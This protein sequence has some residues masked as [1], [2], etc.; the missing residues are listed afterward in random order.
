MSWCPNGGKRTGGISLWDDAWATSELTVLLAEFVRHTSA[1]ARMVRHA[2]ELAPRA[3]RRVCVR[4]HQMRQEPYDTVGS[5][6]VGVGTSGRRRPVSSPATDLRKR[7]IDRSCLGPPH[8]RVWNSRV[9]TQPIRARAWPLSG[10]I[11][12]AANKLRRANQDAPHALTLAFG[13]PPTDD[14][15]VHYGCV[16]GRFLAIKILTTPAS[17][18]PIQHITAEGYIGLRT[19]AQGGFCDRLLL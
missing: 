14:G 7:R 5:R 19:S 4:A 10:S 12:S 3:T 13:R 17:S 11:C 6:A 9:G 16:S 18:T 1:S 8:A 2:A 15:C